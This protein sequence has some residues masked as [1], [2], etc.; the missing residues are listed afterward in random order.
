MIEPNKVYYTIIFFPVLEDRSVEMIRNA[1]NFMELDM[2]KK[3]GAGTKLTLK[4]EKIYLLFPGDI[5]FFNKN[6]EFIYVLHN[7]RKI[8]GI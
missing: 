2:D 5:L 4:E 1:P 6:K 3:Y 8:I 7:K